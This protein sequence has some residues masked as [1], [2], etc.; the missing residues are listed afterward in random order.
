MGRICWYG[1]ELEGLVTDVLM[2]Q[3]LDDIWK[4]SCGA[5]GISGDVSALIFL[6]VLMKMPWWFDGESVQDEQAKGELWS[7]EKDAILAF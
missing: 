6:Y 1:K 5:I 4:H 3:L 7:Y 2:L